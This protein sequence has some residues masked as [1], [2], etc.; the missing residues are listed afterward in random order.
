MCRSPNVPTLIKQFQRFIDVAFLHGIL[1]RFIKV[2]FRIVQHRFAFLRR[3]GAGAATG[4]A[5]LPTV[6]G[7]TGQANNGPTIRWALLLVFTFSF[8]TPSVVWRAATGSGISG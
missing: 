6:T 2:A 3:D 8:T 4:A 1:N 5:V 7:G